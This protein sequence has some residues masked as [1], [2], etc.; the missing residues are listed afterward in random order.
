MIIKRTLLA[1]T[2]FI[3]ATATAA[4]API[5]KGTNY[6]SPYCGCCK[7]WVTHMKDNGFELEN[8]YQENLTPIKIKLGVLPE[9]ASCHT[10]QIEGY[11]FEGHIPAADIKR[12]LANK[13][14]RMKGLAVGGMPMGS[15]GM[16]YGDQKDSYS[17]VAF[18][19]KGRTMVWARHN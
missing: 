1:C 19:D 6:L 2:L 10:A 4:T 14:T 18:D 8:V 7:E 13:P 11:T 15:P 5:I 9:Y 3:S 17:V 12:F 16:E